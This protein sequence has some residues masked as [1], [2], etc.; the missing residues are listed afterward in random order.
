MKE[1]DFD[2]LSNLAQLNPQS[3]FAFRAMAIETAMVTIG[4]SSPKLHTL[5]DQ[6][7][8]IRANTV[9]PQA[10]LL[11]ISELMEQ[12]LGELKEAIANARIFIESESAAN[13]GS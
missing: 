13:G 6:I 1:Y 9:S 12:R 3:F 7:D 2:E 11:A 5:Q 8:V 10:S 4:D